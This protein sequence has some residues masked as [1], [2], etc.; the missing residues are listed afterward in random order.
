MFVLVF[1]NDDG[2]VWMVNDIVTYTAHDRPSD[3]AATPTAY[4]KNVSS[5][6]VGGLDDSFTRVAM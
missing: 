3:R 4:N 6:S 1:A 5:L 2:Y